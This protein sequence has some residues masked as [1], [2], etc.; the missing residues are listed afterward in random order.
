MLGEGLAELGPVGLAAGLAVLAAI[1]SVAW[2]LRDRDPWLGAAIVVVPAH[3]LL[4]FS[5]WVS[6]VALPWAVLLGWALARLDSDAHQSSRSS[7]YDPVRIMVTAC[8]AVAVA[9]ALLHA[10]S[11]WMEWSVEPSDPAARRVA[12]FEQAWRLA[13]W[14]TTPALEAAIAALE[15]DERTALERA[16]RRLDRVA[17]L[18][19][20][21][22]DVAAV[23]ARVEKALGDEAAAA[24]ALWNADRRRRVVDPTVSDA[25]SG[26]WAEGPRA[27]RR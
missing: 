7:R 1:G 17:W 11:R 2:R 8:G 23:R 26:T 25:G 18:R 6:G 3:N 4:D 10:T 24:A 5:W 14:R 15:T 19:P 27:A 21:S 22:A 12:T 20:F 16:A 13:P 9:V